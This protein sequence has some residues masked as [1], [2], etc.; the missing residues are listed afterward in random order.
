MASMTRAAISGVVS[1]VG[2]HGAA[3]VLTGAA[4]DLVAHE[5]VDDPGRDAGVLQPSRVGVAEVV[6]AMQVDRVSRGSRSTGSGEPRPA[7]S[8]WSSTSTAAK[9]APCSSR[10]STPIVAGWMGRPV[11][12]SRAASWSTRCGHRRA[13]PSARA[14]PS[15]EGGRPGRSAWPGRPGRCGAGCAGTAPYGHR[16]D[17]RPVGAVEAGGPGRTPHHAEGARLV[18]LLRLRGTP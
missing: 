9:P 11:M 1:V 4:R 18:S 12:A 3:S 17:A 7:S 14:V 6:G 8:S 15:V 5:F 13:G 10:R 2:A 16:G